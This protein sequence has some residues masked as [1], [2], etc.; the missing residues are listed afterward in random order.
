MC[1]TE[2]KARSNIIFLLRDNAK[3]SYFGVQNKT[4]YNRTIAVDI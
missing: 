3:I 1:K 4:K 2:K